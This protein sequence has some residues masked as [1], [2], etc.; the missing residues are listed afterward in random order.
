M[1]LEML[2][3][4]DLHFDLFGCESAMSQSMFFVDELDGDDGIGAAEGSCLADS[5]KAR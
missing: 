5:A 3:Q 1:F 2:V 4:R